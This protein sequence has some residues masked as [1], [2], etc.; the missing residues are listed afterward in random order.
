MPH[1][2]MYRTCI[3]VHC[4]V[5]IYP[6]PPMCTCF[7][8]EPP[9]AAVKHTS[10]SQGTDLTGHSILPSTDIFH[11]QTSGKEKH[12][13]NSLHE[14]STAALGPDNPPKPK[15]TPPTLHALAACRVP[16]SSGPGRGAAALTQKHPGPG[17]A[18]KG[19]PHEQE[20]DS[21]RSNTGSWCPAT[22]FQSPPETDVTHSGGQ[23]PSKTHTRRGCSRTGLRP[24]LAVFVC[25]CSVYLHPCH[26]KRPCSCHCPLQHDAHIQHWSLRKKREGGVEAC[27]G[28]RIGPHTTLLAAALRHKRGVVV[29]VVGCVAALM[30]ASM[31]RETQQPHITTPAAV[32]ETG[33]AKNITL[34]VPQAAP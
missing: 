13:T 19:L 3:R 2:H 6:P 9:E 32:M 10:H 14:T 15:S 31:E 30:R 33:G 17:K 16:P 28:T 29:V 1:T 25:A 18:K 8:R 21:P 7:S 5:H 26:S 4:C 20:Q 27:R 24:G 11:P 34:S 12:R 23:Q 22:R